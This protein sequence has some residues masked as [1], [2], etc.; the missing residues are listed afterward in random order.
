M[1]NTLLILLVILVT[2]LASSAQPAVDA[3][4]TE[5]GWS[6][7]GGLGFT[8]GPD[9]FLMQFEA[10]YHYSSNITIGP[11]LQIGVSDATTLVT[12]SAN[13][14]LSFDLSS[15]AD[16]NLHNLEPFVNGGIGFA[17]VDRK[18]VDEVGFLMNLG[19]G[20]AYNFSTQV[21]AQSAMQFNI[22]PGGAAGEKFFYTWQM[23]GIRYRF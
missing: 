1:R 18:K 10:P 5:R 19:F 12:M 16:E 15:V 7:E 3:A 14:R 21:A 2:P 20:L 4:A 23:A 8:S 6:F 9:T 11:Q 22:I 13:T 17:F